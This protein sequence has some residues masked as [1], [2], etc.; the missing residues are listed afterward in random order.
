MR[1]AHPEA[2]D[3]FLRTPDDPNFEGVELTPD[4]VYALKVTQASW[5]HAGRW[6][7]SEW[8]QELASLHHPPRDP[9]EPW[10]HDHCHFCHSAAFSRKY[11]GDLRAGWTAEYLP[12]LSGEEQVAAGY[13][14]VCPTCFDRLRGHFDWIVVP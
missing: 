1:V 5:M 6:R 11:D 9:E 8:S 4:E 14:W 7:W 13:Y 12:A 10:D 2:E 3:N